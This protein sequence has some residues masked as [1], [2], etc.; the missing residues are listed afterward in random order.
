MFGRAAG[1]LEVNRADGF[2]ASTWWTAHI[3][4][5][6]VTELGLA[7][8][9]YLIQEYEPFT[10]PMGS[11]AALAEES[12]R[13]DHFGVFSSELLRGYFREHRLGVYARGEAAGDASSSSFQNALSEVDP[14]DRSWLEGRRPRRLLFYSRP[15]PHAARNMFELGLLAIERAVEE[16]AFREGW[17]LRGIGALGAGRSIR[18]GSGA[19]L[20]VL[21]RRGQSDYARLLTEHD[22]GLALMLT[23]HPSLVPIEMARAGLLVVTN[24]FENKTAEALAAISSSLLAVPASIDA[25]AE[26]LVRAAAAVEDVDRRL[27]G[28]AVN[29]S[30]DWSQ[31]FD[32]RLIDLVAAYLTR[33]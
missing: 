4:N 16:A 21:P 31:S 9:V 22:L 14:P 11:Y 28:T 26:A 8:F 1:P 3:A 30:L 15:E 5:R 12:Y 20:E 17:E 23:P 25:L 18:L 2:V 6:A 19:E 13:F 24:T 10:F 27:A 29:W 32:D 7:G 33:G